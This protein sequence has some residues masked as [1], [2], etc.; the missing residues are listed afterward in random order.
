MKFIKR[1]QRIVTEY[2]NSIK[3][4]PKGWEKEKYKYIKEKH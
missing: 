2:I 4:A 3:I 1:Y